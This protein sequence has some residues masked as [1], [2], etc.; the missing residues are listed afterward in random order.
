[1]S[2]ERIEQR[3]SERMLSRFNEV[4]N[5][6]KQKNLTMREAAMDIGVGK[7]VEAVFTKGLMP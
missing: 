6:A 2:I 4:Y 3:L 7:V 5:Y 1:M